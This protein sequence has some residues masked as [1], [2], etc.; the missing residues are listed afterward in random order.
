MVNKI[1][2][3]NM[4]MYNY[5]LIKLSIFPIEFCKNKIHKNVILQPKFLM[6]KVFATRYLYESLI[7]EM[8]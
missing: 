1:L 8:S 3:D 4:K 5:I 6:F 2:R 7:K